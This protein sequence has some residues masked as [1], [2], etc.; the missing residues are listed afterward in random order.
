MQPSQTTLDLSIILV[1]HN[2]EECLTGALRRAA[3]AHRG[4]QCRVPRR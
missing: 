2:G 3:R 1:N 4:Q